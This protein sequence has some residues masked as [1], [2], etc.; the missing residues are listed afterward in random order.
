MASKGWLFI[1]N[2]GYSIKA[3]FMPTDAP[4][5]YVVIPNGVGASS[6][7]GR[8]IVGTTLSTLNQYHSLLLRRPLDQGLLVDGELQSFIWDSVL[9]HFTIVDEQGVDF[10]F[11]IPHGTPAAV[12]EQ[13]S[14]VLSLA[15]RFRSVTVV[16]SSVLALV[17]AEVL[18][19]AAPTGTGVV[20]DCG[21]SSTTVTP[22]VAYRP[23]RCSIGRTL[24]GGKLLTNCLK[25]ALS[26]SQVNLLEDPWI[27]NCIKEACCRVAE[28]GGAKVL[29][30]QTKACR[31]RPRDSGDD[32]LSPVNNAPS[33]TIVY[34][35]P[36]VPAAMPSGCVAPP[37]QLRGPFRDA[38]TVKVA[39]EGFIVPEVL[40]SPN[41]IGLDNSLGVSELY[42]RVVG[43]EQTL[44][45]QLSLL[46]GGIRRNTVVCGGT[47]N[48][49]GFLERMAKD[50]CEGSM[51]TLGGD[52]P[53][54]LSSHV[55]D[56]STALF[57]VI[58][59]ASSRSIRHRTQELLP[60][61]GI[62]A[63]MTAAAG[64]LLELR[65]AIQAAGTVACT[66]TPKQVL[67]SFRHAAGG[68][69]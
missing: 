19:G 24:V 46:S 29:L 2:G 68:I 34:A 14:T 50:M 8:G 52:P 40:F 62:K 28:R 51:S 20:V 5:S 6:A 11:T 54:L 3:M 4:P 47:T 18:H 32:A 12:A 57:G 48:L 43:S 31:K 58:G 45:G 49:P 41:D 9:Q 1:D 27:V 64:P 7:I 69:L 37:H 36:T 17:G 65:K 44:L 39:H 61:V 21:F 63:I 30:E 66:G 59:T 35:L 42:H 16:S 13:W 56:N 60:L 67:D 26:F 15:F 38:Q 33:G 55:A 25:E 10:V 53:A 22:Y 23:M